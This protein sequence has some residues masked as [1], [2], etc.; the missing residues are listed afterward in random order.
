MQST[1]VELSLSADGSAVRA[2]V[3]RSNSGT[4]GGTKPLEMFVPLM[5]DKTVALRVLLDNSVLEVFVQ[6][7][8]NGAISARVYPQADDALG[9]SLWSVSTAT[10]IVVVEA[11]AWSM[12]DALVPVEQQFPGLVSQ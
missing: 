1:G 3:D 2:L 9:I 4:D 8:R 5:G 11:T 7:G 6:D 12:S 10:P